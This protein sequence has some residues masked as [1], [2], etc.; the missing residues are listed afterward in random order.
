MCEEEDQNRNE[1][2]QLGKGEFPQS[3]QQ[4][5]YVLN[6]Y[7]SGAH[8]E[9]SDYSDSNASSYGSSKA[10]GSSDYDGDH[11]DIPEEEVREFVKTPTQPKQGQPKSK[12]SQRR[13][14]VMKENGDVGSSDLPKGLVEWQEGV[15]M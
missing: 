7:A 5:G 4:H 8:S 12:R 3:T 6:G 2:A 1:W 11:G 10:Q 14:K 15:F 13:E 9:G